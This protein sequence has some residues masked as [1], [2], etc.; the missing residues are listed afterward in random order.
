MCLSDLIYTVRPCLIHTWQCNSSQGHGTARPSKRRPVGYLPTFGFFR[1]PRRVPQR[2]LSE[3]QRS[4]PTTVKSGSSTLQNKWSVK[5]LDYQFVYF[6]LPRGLPQRTRHCQSRAGVRH[7]MCEVTAQHGGGSAWVR[8]STCESAL[9]GHCH[10]K[11]H[12]FKLGL[13]DN[14]TCGRWK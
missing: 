3:A 4:I 2:L 8:H 13:A 9:T 5:L 10:L 1:L 11:W 6:Q 7:G 12:L 14:P